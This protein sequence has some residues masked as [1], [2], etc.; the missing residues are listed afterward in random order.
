MMGEFAVVGST[1]LGKYNGNIEANDLDIICSSRDFKDLLQQHVTSIKWIKPT[2]SGMAA[3]VGNEIWEAEF[4]DRDNTSSEKVFDYISTH[5]NILAVDTPACHTWFY[6]DLNTLYMLK[7]SHRYLKNSP[8]FRKTMTDI[9][10]MRD[11]GAFIPAEL[12][13]LYKARMKAT[14][15]YAHPKLN[16]GKMD[17][18][19][20][21]GLEYVYDHDSL[22]EA[23]K[24]LDL[25]AYTYYMEE[26]AEVNCSKEKFFAADKMVRLYGVLEEAL[27][28]A[29]ERSVIPHDTPADKAFS[30]ALMKVCT[31]I[32]SGWFREYAWENFDQV[33]HLA[34][35]DFYSNYNYVKK[36]QEGVENGTVK[37]F[38]EKP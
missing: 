17:F 34:R 18:F 16:Q 15:N 29:L 32:T 7:M 38:E 24:H 28:L 10:K 30:I 5:W 9:R 4:T 36:F 11:M 12:E 8:H 22:H 3:K 37:L 25:P 2:K 6:A 23:V 14:Y 26:G 31:S 1:A 20:D 27:V 33:V 35:T 21:D 13:E 19:S